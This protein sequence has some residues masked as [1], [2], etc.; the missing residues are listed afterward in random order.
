M[1]Y[2]VSFHVGS[3]C[4]SVDS[5]RLAVEYCA[6]VAQ[7][8]KALGQELRLLD[9]GGGYMTDASARHYVA[10]EMEFLSFE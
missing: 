3:G 8:S 6:S 4:F 5:F 1:L 2:G 9:L 7:Q 10:H